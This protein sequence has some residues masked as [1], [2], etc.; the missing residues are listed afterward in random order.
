MFISFL[1]ALRQ[2]GLTASLHEY[3]ALLEALQAG[4][5]RTLDEFYALGKTILVNDER[6]LD[7]YDLVFDR[8]FGALSQLTDD[9]FDQKIPA[10]W[11]A[12]LLDPALSDAEKGQVDQYDDPDALMARFRELL[13]QQDDAHHGGDTWIGTGGT[14]PFGHSGYHPE[15]YRLGGKG[16]ERKAIKVWQR[17]DFQNL[18]DR[19]ELNTR[20]MKLAFKRLRNW[21]RSGSATEFDLERTIRQTSDNGGLL[22]I[23]MR[24]PKK[25]QIKVLMLM[26]VGGSMDD[27]VR[28]CEQLFSAARWAFKHL[29]FYY[30]HNCVYESVWPD[31]QRRWRERVPTLDL[32]HRYNGDYKL[33]LV[34]D[35]AMSP[36]EI[37]YRGGSVEH[38]NDEPG[39]N[40]LRRL[41]EHFH[42]LVWI[43]PN[44]E[45]EWDYYESTRMLRQFTEDRMF[46]M[47]ID[48]LKQA[49]QCLK[50]PGQRYENRIW[51]DKE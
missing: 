16:K 1:Y 19:V 33:I 34:G 14:S 18:D 32:L 31:N 42:H 15:G 24:P 30:F 23:S 44:P 6:E 51:G 11:L 2:N 29:A 37:Y 46:P 35:A 49:M 40:W 13:E 47:T 48:G 36:Y 8:Y 41:K 28:L 45:Y 21:V 25:N 3:L 9:F 38:Y 26:D 4:L 17:R 39:V 22:D 12:E 5:V 43:N 7:R 20:N 50:K 27:H 10:E